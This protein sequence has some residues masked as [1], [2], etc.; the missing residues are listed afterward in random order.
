MRRCN[1]CMR[2]FLSAMSWRCKL[3][4]WR[5]KT[6]DSICIRKEAELLGVSFLSQQNVGKKERE[7][8][9]SFFT[10]SLAKL[11]SRLKW[12][13]FSLGFF[14]VLAQLV[15]TT[16]ILCGNESK[17]SFCNATA[18]CCSSW[19]LSTNLLKFNFKMPWQLHSY[20]SV[21]NDRMK[22]S[23]TFFFFFSIF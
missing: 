6:N 5:R 2:N 10:Q 23:L 3:R 16:N 19:K 17:T 8:R 21:R 11:E 20:F 1:R 22:K 12:S 13:S 14:L 9:R 18:A 15:A 4:K 7:K